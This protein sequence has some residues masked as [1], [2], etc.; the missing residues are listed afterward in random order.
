MNLREIGWKFVDWMHLGRGGGP[1]A[2]FCEPVVAKLKVCLCALTEHHAVKAYWGSGCIAPR[3]L[4]LDTRWRRAVSFTHR[5]LYPQGK[6]RSGRGGE[7][8]YSQ[9]LPGLEPRS[10]RPSPRAIPLRSPG[11]CAGGGPLGWCG[12][13]G[14]SL[15]G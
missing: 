4:G 1:V 14:R 7:K 12:G 8:K 11:S 2:G 6:S 9:P 5:P 10:S 15:T 3:I 13:G